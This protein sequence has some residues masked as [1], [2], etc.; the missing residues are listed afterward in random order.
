MTMDLPTH[1]RPVVATEPSA[2]VA[3]TFVDS[4]VAAAVVAAAA[5]SVG[6]L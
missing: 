1:L 4:S 5:H 2:A 6:L 3:E